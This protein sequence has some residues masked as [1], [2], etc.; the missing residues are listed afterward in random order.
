MFHTIM[1]LTLI[2]FFVGVYNDST[3]LKLACNHVSFVNRP[4]W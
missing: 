1:E 2:S 3:A 4:I